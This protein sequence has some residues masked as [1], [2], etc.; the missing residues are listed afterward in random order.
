MYQQARVGESPEWPW[1]LL[2]FTPEDR[3]W[4]EIT[5][6]PIPENSGEWI[7]E[8]PTILAGGEFDGE[9]YSI[10]GWW[11]E[12]PEGATGATVSA[13][14]SVLVE[15]PISG[16]P[17]TRLTVHFTAGDLPGR[18]VFHYGYSEGHKMIVDVTE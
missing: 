5:M 15:A 17:A 14:P 16:H 10:G 3:P 18:Y 8:G 9:V 6:R 12:G 7:P 13:D 11:I 4:G 2:I 1:D